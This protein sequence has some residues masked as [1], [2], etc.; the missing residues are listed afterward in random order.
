[1]NLMKWNFYEGAWT[2]RKTRNIES[3][4]IEYNSNRFSSGELKR[5]RQEINNY[6]KSGQG[7]SNGHLGN[8]NSFPGKSGNGNGNIMSGC[9]RHVEYWFCHELETLYIHKGIRKRWRIK[10]FSP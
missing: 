2:L 10:M 6:Y 8:D 7:Q 3:M 9:N 1:M 5:G 4:D